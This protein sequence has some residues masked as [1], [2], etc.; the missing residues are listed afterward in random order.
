EKTWLNAARCCNILG[1]LAGL[2]D[3][4]LESNEYVPRRETKPTPPPAI[5]VPNSPE[6]RLEDA[7]EEPI[8]LY[9]SSQT[10]VSSVREQQRLSPDKA[11]SPSFLSMPS[12]SMD[13]FAAPGI[14][15][16]PSQPN[17]DSLAT[18]FW[19]MPTSLDTNEWNT[20]F[21]N[22]NSQNQVEGNINSL[23]SNNETLPSPS[24]PFIRSSLFNQPMSL[25]LPSSPS[26]STLLGF[27]DH[28]S[29]PL[30]SSNNSY[31]PNT[32]DTGFP[33]L[34]FAFSSV[35]YL[36]FQEIVREEVDRSHYNSLI[37]QFQM[38]PYCLL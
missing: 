30:F 26:K 1:E 12:A 19:G 32:N 8:P 5:A 21:G 33:S 35:S 27:L 4:R 10:P 23:L 20:Y 18:A 15:P 36:L 7:E 34:A 28:P 11:P 6:K 31:S 25:D 24:S 9:S 17:S 13:P 16:T 38:L 22:L 29:T 3:I 14:I 37:P 2:K